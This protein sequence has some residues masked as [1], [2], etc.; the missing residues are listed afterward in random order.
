MRVSDVMT[1]TVVTAAPDTPFQRLVD[2]ML[3]H[4]VSGLPIVD[5]DRRPIGIVTEADLVSKQAFGARRR[6]L[7]AAAD[8]AFRE[9]NIWAE[10]ARGL[11]AGAIMSAPVRTVRP[12]DQ[13]RLAAA[14]MVTMGVKRLPVVGDDGRLVGIVSRTDVMRLFHRS[15]N[16][17]ALDVQ[18]VLDDPLLVPEDHIVTASVHDGV[19]TLHGAVSQSSH[20]RLIDA[21]V[22]QVAG[23]VDVISEIDGRARST[24]ENT[25]AR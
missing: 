17:V 9:E 25:G 21:M 10:K 6:P 8:F 24:G 15:D 5:V 22:R 12:D 4:G 18:R 3:Q 1:T 19:V 23:V 16:E 13:L 7:D 2:L 14:R 11:T 20:I